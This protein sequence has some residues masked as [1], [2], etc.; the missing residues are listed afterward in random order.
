[1][2]S[3]C[4]QEVHTTEHYCLSH[5][6]FSIPQY[7]VNSNNFTAN[8]DINTNIYIATYLGKC[9]KDQRNRPGTVLDSAKLFHP[10]PWTSL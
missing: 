3:E 7:A 1:M 5:A 8:R 10:C 2:V 4:T 6:H 9:G